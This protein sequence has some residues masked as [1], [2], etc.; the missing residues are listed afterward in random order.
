M[1]SLLY[2]LYNHQN[3]E[4]DGIFGK[5]IRLNYYS[6]VVC[7]IGEYILKNA[8]GSEDIYSNDESFNEETGS[9]IVY[10]EE[11]NSNSEYYELI[12]KYENSAMYDENSG[13]YPF[14]IYMKNGTHYSISMT[15][16]QKYISNNQRKLQ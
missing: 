5:G 10:N 11:T 1:K 9:K 13:D 7:G 16:S 12:D 3:R 2:Y 8:D 4:D 6:K 14:G 15:S